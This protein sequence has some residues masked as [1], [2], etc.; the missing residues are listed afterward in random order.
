VSAELD[1]TGAD[2]AGARF[3][4]IG[5]TLNLRDLG[6]YPVA[7]GGSTRW[8]TLLRSDSLHKLSRAD[9]AKLADYGVR[10]VIDLRSFG[11]VRSATNRIAE[12][13]VLQYVHVPFGDPVLVARSRAE[14]YCLALH[15]RQRE[16]QKVLTVLAGERVLPAILQCSAGR[17]RTGLV[18]ALVLAM[19]GVPPETIAADY[20]LRSESRSDVQMERPH[21]AML[22]TLT[23]LESTFGGIHEYLHVIGVGIR[24]ITAL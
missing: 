23:Y 2:M 14:L 10:T 5:S 4:Q 12:S 6:G 1:P 8:R 18:V 3:L 7:Q 16:F 24:E 19:V 13:E 22:H 15:R 20:A 9:Q 11:E 21:E 17:D